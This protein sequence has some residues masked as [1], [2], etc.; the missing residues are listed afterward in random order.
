MIDG[1]TGPQRFFMGWA[2]V[3]RSKIR[4][5]AL[6]A[7]L[8]SDPHS[9]AE[10]RVLGPLRNVDAFYSAFDVKKGDEMYLAPEER[11]KIW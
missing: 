10:Y 7:R 8:L 3:W 5:D 1:L 2:Q 11:V 9:P 6:R 4:E